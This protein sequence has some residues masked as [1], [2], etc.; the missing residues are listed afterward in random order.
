MADRLLIA[1]VYDTAVG[2]SPLDRV[3]AAAVKS[4]R[5]TAEADR[6]IDHFVAEART[7]GHSW[8]EI[9]ERLG[10][11][12][13][14]VR[15]RFVDR[16][17]LSGRER[18]MPRLRRCVV[19]AGELAERH[20]AAE[21]SSAHLLLALASNDGL[22]CTVLHRLGAVP[23]KLAPALHGHLGDG[24]PA[25]AVPPESGELREVLRSAGAFAFERGHD[26]VGTEHVLFVLAGDPGASSRRVLEDLGIGFADI[27]R[28]LARCLTIKTTKKRPGRRRAACRCSFCGATDPA[29]L[30]HG[31]GV[32]ICRTC[33]RSAV[34]VTTD[35]HR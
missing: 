21:I 27:K 33:A 6:L 34:D 26:Y 9:G 16:V 1:D 7:A 32:W 4:V 25:S 12:K 15:E 29:T 24:T 3:S 2:D 18:F 22:A 5:L 14:A 17:G 23:D 10:V 35:D 11:T 31:P 28:E 19:A 8:T 13:Q 20:G 30:V